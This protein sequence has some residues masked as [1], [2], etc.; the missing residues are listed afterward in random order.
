M[1]A[2]AWLNT[3]G[4]N[5]RAE[6]ETP[7]TPRSTGNPMRARHP[8]AMGRPLAVV[9]RLPPLPPCHAE[10]ERVAEAGHHH[11]EKA[12]AAQDVHHVEHDDAG[13]GCRIHICVTLSDGVP[14]GPGRVKT[15]TY[16]RAL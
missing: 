2:P 14:E 16:A 13:M 9:V 6:S 5:D 4:L 1:H 12:D 15:R 10:G 3:M 8:H 11:V 7:C